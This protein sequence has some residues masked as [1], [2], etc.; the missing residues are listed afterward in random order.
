M[1]VNDIPLRSSV[2]ICRMEPTAQT[3]GARI[4]TRREEKKFDRGAFAK[5]VGIP[6]STLAE[7]ENGKQKTSTKLHKIAAQLG[8][9]IEWLE[10]GQG[11]IEADPNTAAHTGVRA[12]PSS[13]GVEKHTR[14]EILVS[15]EGAALGAEWDK[16]EG[17]EYRQLAH[18][19]V[20]GLVAAQKRAARRPGTRLTTLEKPLVQKRL[21]NPSGSRPRLTTEKPDR[22]KRPQ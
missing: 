3:I 14:H 6:Y 12:P 15:R 16:I 21:V 9:N 19:F 2:L 20:Y 22:P 7:I 8:V 18:D 5:L 13:Y 4:R 17:D 1:S 11:P 10:T